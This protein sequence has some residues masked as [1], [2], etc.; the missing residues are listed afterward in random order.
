MSDMNT[1]G[2]SPVNRPH[3]EPSVMDGSMVN[4]FSQP[5]N[6]YQ[7]FGFGYNP[8]MNTM[9]GGYGMG[10]GFGMM[11]NMYMNSAHGAPFVPM[12]ANRMEYD[13]QMAQ[14]HMAQ[15][16]LQGRNTGQLIGAGTGAL[17]GAA[18]T[19]GTYALLGSTVGPV[20][21]LV[22]ALVGAGVGLVAGGYLGSLKGG[23]SAMMDDAADGR[24]D[25]RVL[26]R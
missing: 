9:G 8:Y 1:G 17:L 4:A 19:V 18:G 12:L 23:Y 10:A 22:G 25:G 11:P 14:L 5:A 20:G 24:L 15:G 16:E 7:S 6:A 26:G 21:T 2:I 3:V 13:A